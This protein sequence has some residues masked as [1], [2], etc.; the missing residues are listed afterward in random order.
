MTR[1]RTALPSGDPYRSTAV[2]LDALPKNIAT[3]LAEYRKLTARADAAQGERSNLSFNRHADDSEAKRLDAE[4]AD[5]A[6][7]TGKPL[8]GTPNADALIRRRATVEHE[9]A[10]LADAVELVRGDLTNAI[11][12][13]YASD[14]ARTAMQDAR[15]RL[16][17]ASETFAEA[18]RHA[19][20]AKALDDFLNGM[21]WD[22]S[23]YVALT[24]IAP[25]TQNQL[26][27]YLYDIPPLNAL[28]IVAA[29]GHIA[30]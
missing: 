14:T 21:E 16:L 6:A 28:P 17:K 26:G 2:P 11:M 13:H 3:L 4:A 19:A 8:N 27:P 5:Q 29:L 20:S 30:D 12:E 15:T 23:V 1:I 7:R 9:A 10:A 22:T 18:L 25:D 24:D